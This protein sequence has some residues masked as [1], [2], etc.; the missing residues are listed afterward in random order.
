[1]RR[2]GFAVM[3]VLAG[4]TLVFSQADD[5]DLEK[6]VVTPYRYTQEIGKVSSSVTVITKD[7]I[8]NSNAKDIIDVLRPVPGVVVRDFYGTG[9]KASVD[10]RGFGEQGGMNALI[11]IDGRRVNEIDLSG[12]DWAQ[13]PL[14]QI[15]KIEVVRG[16]GSVLYGDNAVSGV[17]NI[18]TKKGKG[19][20]SIEL[21]VQGGS[22]DMNSQSLSFSGSKGGLSYNLT[23]SHES[24]HGY[25]KNSYYETGD[26]GTNLSY[27]VNPEFSL[28]FR[29]GFH[30]AEYGLPGPLSSSDLQ[31][32]SRRSSKYGDD[33]ANDKD[34]YFMLGL[35]KES[36]NIGDFVVDVSFRRK[37]ADTFWLTSSMGWNPVYLS[38]IDTIGITPKYVLDKGIFGHD[39]KLIL[40]TDFYKADYS[41]DNYNNAMALQSASDINKIT[42]GFYIQEEFSILKNLSL[43]AGYR[44]EGA[45]YEFDYHDNSGWNPDVDKDIRPNMKAFDGGLLFNYKDDSSVFFNINQSFRFPA[46]DE[47]FT[48]GTINTELKSQKAQNFEIGVKHRFN[49]DLKLDLAYF[50]MNVENELYYNPAGGPFGWGANENYDKT[51]HQ[52]LEFAFD[53]KIHK[54]I[55]FF[56]NYTYTKSTFRAGAYEDKNIPMVP[57]HKGSVGL[58]FLLPKDITL[59]ILGNY[60]GERYFIN[61][62]AN[63]FSRLNGYMSADMNISYT[64]KDF[65]VTAG[66]NNVFDKEYSEIGVCNSIT[67]AKNYYPSPG[68][69]F[70]LKL[71]CKF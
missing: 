52:G 11:L 26:C 51:R 45:K 50:F 30:K 7:D 38:R 41:M 12:V 34:Y 17:V 29:Q 57:R 44:Y 28:S 19:K 18:I 6:I 10:I 36:E 59:N 55:S 65:T 56:A 16:W 43:L 20:P 47:Y 21:E 54:S 13:I 48:W 2:F 63:N 8:K 39:F 15:E 3:L 37:E 5:V 22:Y 67:G 23:G 32:M 53:S 27:E 70:N 62:Q 66:V 46:A 60:V 31:K 9:V 71:D 35:D 40:G 33:H 69:N 25:R 61:D 1:M 24:T 64:Y 4:R 49:D 42:A 14:E 58:Q 68:R